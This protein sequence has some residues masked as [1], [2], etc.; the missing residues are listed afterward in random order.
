MITFTQ[1]DGR[2]IRGWANEGFTGICIDL[3]GA[4]INGEWKGSNYFTAIPVS[5]LSYR[6]K[7]R[8]TQARAWVKG[9]TIGV[10][11]DCGHEYRITFQD[12]DETAFQ[13]ALANLK[14]Q[15]LLMP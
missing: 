11:D 6:R 2:Q 14:A 1:N 3:H 4:V 15:E 9:Q 10:I 7:E 12:E 8:D 5:S 13:E